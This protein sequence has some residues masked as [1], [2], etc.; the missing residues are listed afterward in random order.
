MVGFVAMVSMI[1]T[2]QGSVALVRACPYRWG[3]LEIGEVPNEGKEQSYAML[4]GVN[5]GGLLTFFRL[6]VRA[7]LTLVLIALMFG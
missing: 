2:P 1:I 6:P 5:W 7:L 4:R 3:L